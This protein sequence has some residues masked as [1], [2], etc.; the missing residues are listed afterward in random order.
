M[1]AIKHN[2]LMRLKGFHSPYFS[3]PRRRP[4]CTPPAV[5]VG[6]S[7]SPI[8]GAPEETALCFGCTRRKLFI[9]YGNS[10]GMAC[11]ERQNNR[12]YI[13]MLYDNRG[14]YALKHFSENHRTPDLVQCWK[15][16]QVGFL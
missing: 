10:A 11:G 14:Y 7:S 16:F 4:S 6:V 5:E 2:A 9:V 13:I 15:K 12:P 3:C 1:N 8:T